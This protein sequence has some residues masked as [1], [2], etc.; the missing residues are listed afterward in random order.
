MTEKF[1]VLNRWTGKVQFAAEI[2]V[3]PDMTPSVKLGL[4]VKW[5]YR[6]GADLR[7]LAPLAW[8]IRE[9]LPAEGVASV[10]GPSA[11]GKSFLALDMAA[12]I[13]SGRPWFGYRTSAAPVVYCALEGEAGFRLRVAAWEAHNGESLPADLRMMLQPFKLTEAQDVRDLA[14]A[15]LRL[16]GR[17]VTIIDTLNRAAPTADEN[18]S[19]DMGA[20]L[21]A[22]KALQAMTGGLVLLV[23]HTGKDATKGLRGH[24]SLIAALDAA[25]EVTR[26]GDRRQWCLHKSK[27]G[28]DGSIS[29]FRLRSVEL[30][31]DEEG[32]PVTSCV[33]LP[34]DSVEQ[35][36]RARLPKGGNQRIAWDTLGPLFRA[37]VVG[38][39]GAPPQRPCIELEA[40][41][42]A[43]ARRLTVEPDRRT[44]RARAAITGM[45]SSG[46]LSCHEGWMW[47]V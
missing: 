15:V 12:A 2:T 40:A 16:G 14:D 4:A 35:V 39:A 1:D 28:H 21:E 13:A 47:V 25:I 38:R 8:R 42:A 19:K 29:P 5:G 30:G 3:T 32:E 17:A 24:S 23:H 27:D 44:E 31:N 33:V 6:A 36:R 11:S 43:V 26:P 41:I 45:V 46:L 22:C 9:V 20:I 34:D 18:S 7:D 10:F 37:G